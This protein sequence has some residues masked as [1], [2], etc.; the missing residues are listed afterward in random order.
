MKSYGI[1]KEWNRKEKREKQKT[2]KKER[3]HISKGHHGWI[4]T[5]ETDDLITWFC[6]RA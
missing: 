4:S 2:I 6:Q 3:G 1:C 5:E